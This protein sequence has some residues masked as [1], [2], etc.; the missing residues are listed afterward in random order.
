[1]DANIIPNET[2]LATWA[3]QLHALLSRTCWNAGEDF[4]EAGEDVQELFMQACCD[5]ASRLETAL[6]E[7]AMAAV[8][9]T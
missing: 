2:E 6:A 5:I 1:M 8:P 9:T 4:R 3:G 7:R